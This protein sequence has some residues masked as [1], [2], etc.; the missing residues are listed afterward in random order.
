MSYKLKQ[1]KLV[2]SAGVVSDAIY[3]NVDAVRKWLHGDGRNNVIKQTEVLHAAAE[4]GHT[5]IC[6]LIIDCDTVPTDELTIAFSDACENEHLSVVQLIV[7]TLGHHCNTQ[8]LDDCLHYAALKSNTDVGNLLLPLTN[9]TDADYMR[10]DLVQACARC[11]DLTRVKQ[12]VYRVGPNVTDVMSHALWTACYKGKG[13][14][15][16]WLMTHT[17]ADVNHSRAVDLN[18]P[19]DSMTSLAITCYEG[20]TSVTKRM[21]TNATLS[22][23]VNMVSEAR[24]NT[25]LHE[26]IWYTRRTPLHDACISGDKAAV[27]DVVYESDVNKQDRNG[28]TAMHYACMNGHFDI[29]EVL[30]SVFANINI[31]DDYGRTPVELCE[32]YGNSELANYIQHNHQMYVSREDDDESNVTVSGQVEH[33]NADTQVTFEDGKGIIDD[34]NEARVIYQINHSTNTTRTDYITNKSKINAD[35]QYTNW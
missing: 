19:R 5:G 26:V 1:Q 29:A 10:W 2:H 33:N 24:C 28:C 3:G 7:R 34:D 17:S 35:T 18:R 22:C 6:K 11:G 9:P 30:L 21:L 23:D 8:L 27:L 25:A 4:K 31:T 32:L 14:T 20:H 16:D 12:F 13:D 15:V